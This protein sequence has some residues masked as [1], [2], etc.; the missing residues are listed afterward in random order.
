MKEYQFAIIG[1]GAAAFAAATKS[2]DLK[3]GKVIM[4]NICIPSPT[5]KF[6]WLMTL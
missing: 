3:I 6:L 5:P 2:A 4:I 1:G